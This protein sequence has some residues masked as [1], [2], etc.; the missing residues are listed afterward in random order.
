MNL[1]VT[2]FRNHHIA[3]LVSMNGLSRK[4]MDICPLMVVLLDNCS[5]G[6]VR[7]RALMA[8]L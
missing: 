1:T 7:V 3:L 6:M 2:T 5:L 8:I 4:V